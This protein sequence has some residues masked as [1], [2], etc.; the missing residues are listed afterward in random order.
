M[1]TFHDILERFISCI[2]LIIIVIR[3]VN[4]VMSFGDNFRFYDVEGKQVG[5]GEGILAPLIQLPKP[6]S[7]NASLIDITRTIVYM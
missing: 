4:R 7:V 6:L 5:L 1:K 3:A 2:T